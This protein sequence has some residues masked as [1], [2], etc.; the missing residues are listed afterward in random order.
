MVEVR[1]LCE[2][3]DDARQGGGLELGKQAGQQEPHGPLPGKLHQLCLEFLHRTPRE[4]VQRRDDAVLMEVRH[5]Q[6]FPD[7]VYRP[8][9]HACTPVAQASGP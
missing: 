5:A 9:S 3:I 7:R 6:S 1:D 8:R 2:V 4:I